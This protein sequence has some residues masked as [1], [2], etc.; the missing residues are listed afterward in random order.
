M[1]P[2]YLCSAIIWLCLLQ[3][4]D[5]FKIAS[6]HQRVSKVLSMSLKGRTSFLFN[7]D[8]NIYLSSILRKSIDSCNLCLSEGSKLI[9]LEFPANRKND[10]SLGETLDTNR[11][12]TRQF[13]NAFDEYGKDLWIIWPDKKVH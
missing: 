13:I 4:F 2:L 1:K 8:Q 5:A 10:L 11:A 7:M 12:F 6:S 9:E 3:K